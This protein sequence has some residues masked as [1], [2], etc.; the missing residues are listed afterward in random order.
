MRRPHQFSDLPPWCKQIFAIRT[1]TRMPRFCSRL[2]RRLDLPGSCDHRQRTGESIS[3]CRSTICGR[4]GVA[5][6]LQRASR[7]A[8]PARLPPS[9]TT[10][11]ARGTWLPPTRAAGT[12][13]PTG[14]QPGHVT[15]TWSDG[16]NLPEYYWSDAPP[17]L[18]DRIVRGA[19]R[20][21]MTV[22]RPRTSAELNR[23]LVRFTL[24]R[25]KSHVR[26]ECR[27]SRNSQWLDIK[28]PKYESPAKRFA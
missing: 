7:T 22:Q 18:V 14:R 28:M 10:R 27:N 6:A 21:R 17:E 26:Y 19:I 1:G 25:L 20:K 23:T 11:S 9:R 13:R 4:I 24:G 3:R 16:G 5:T 8:R 2:G 15:R 12:L